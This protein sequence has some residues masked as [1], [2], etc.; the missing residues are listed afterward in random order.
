LIIYKCHLQRK[1]ANRIKTIN[2]EM[3]KAKHDEKKKLK[4]KIS[5]DRKE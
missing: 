3:D 2:N 1:I 5:I 4:E